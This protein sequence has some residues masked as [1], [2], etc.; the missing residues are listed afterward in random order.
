[1]ES[2]L[3]QIGDTGEDVGKP[4]E[5]IDIV[6]PTCG[7]ELEHHRGALATAVGTD[8]Q[9]GFPSA[10]NGSYRSL[11]GVVRKTDATIV[12]EGGEG[13]PCVEHVIH[14]FADFVFRRVCIRRRSSSGRRDELCVTTVMLAA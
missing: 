11:G 2:G 5:R 8:E 13:R 7:N 6:E 9:P 10:G 12:E 3:G 4:G 1:M 14:L